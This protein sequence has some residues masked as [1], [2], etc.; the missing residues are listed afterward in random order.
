VEPFPGR[1]MCD[2]CSEQPTTQ[3]YACKNFLISSDQ[4]R[5]L[6]VRGGRSLGRVSHLR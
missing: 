5:A 4:N 2:F 3:L 1:E 6:P